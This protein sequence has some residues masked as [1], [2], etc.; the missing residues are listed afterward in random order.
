MSMRNKIWTALLLF[1]LPASLAGCGGS[2]P[3]TEENFAVPVIVAVADSTDLTWSRTYNG[4]VEGIRQ[5]SPAAKLSEAVTSLLVSEGERVKAGQA[6]IE[7]D[8][9]GPTSRFR[10]AEA[11]YEEA[12]RNFDK[13]QRLFAGGAVSEAQRDFYET[14]FKIARA[15]YESA[16]DQ[17]RVKTPIDGTVTDIYVKVGQQVRLGQMLATIAAT[18]TMRL[19]FDVPYFDTRP[20]ARRT[21]VLVRSELDS[22]ITMEGWVQE[23]SESA[24]PVTRTVSVE[25][26]IANPD[27]LL[28]PGMY[29]TGE[30]ILET[31]KGALVIP[32]DALIDRGGV[33]GVFVAAD[34]TAHFTA[35]SEGLV[36][37]DLIEIT[38]GLSRGDRVVSFGQQSLQ[39]GSVIS[40]ESTE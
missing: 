5:A 22:S 20:I 8:K 25:V 3:A 18:D 9:Y 26:L 15:N 7:F 19:T 17:V 12:K 32:A 24:D 28:E 31:H 6:I 33:R 35:V 23:I 36:V 38:A 16:R 37:G 14:Q 2:E 34:S 13:Y 11:S 10:Q 39:D 21:P 4:S 29:V 30:V 40:I 1:L 27:G